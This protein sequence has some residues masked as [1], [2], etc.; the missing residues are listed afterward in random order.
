[1]MSQDLWDKGNLP[2]RLAVVEGVETFV[3]SA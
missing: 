3:S 2:K 1:M